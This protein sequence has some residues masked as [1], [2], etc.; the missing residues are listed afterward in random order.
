MFI[1]VDR[2]FWFFLIVDVLCG[3]L[4]DLVFDVVEDFD[5]RSD[6]VKILLEDF[7][8][9]VVVEGLL[10]VILME[11]NFCLVLVF[12]VVNVKSVELCVFFWVVL[13]G[14]CFVVVKLKYFNYLIL[15]W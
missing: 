15:N 5:V 13:L 10:E 9:D 11:I 1:I 8:I 6:L 14:L 12:E 4:V 2:E 3:D 7:I